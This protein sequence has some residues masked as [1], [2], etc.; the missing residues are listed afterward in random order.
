MSPDAPSVR[1][2]GWNAGSTTPRTWP[3]AAAL[4]TPAARTVRCTAD[5]RS[6]AVEVLAD[7]GGFVLGVDEAGYVHHWQ[8]NAERVH[9]IHP[10]GH[11]E[12][13][14]DTADHDIGDYIA[15]VDAARRWDSLRYGRGLA[16]QFERALEAEA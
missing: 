1:T 13:V 3:S 5:P 7:T 8:T 4:S 10:D 16:E 9:V 14:F 12:H 2:R 15:H 11:R 6:G